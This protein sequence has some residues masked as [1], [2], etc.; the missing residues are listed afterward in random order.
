VYMS[1]DSSKTS[2]VIKAPIAPGMLRDV[3]IEN[4]QKMV[5]DVSYPIRIEKGIVALDGEREFSFKTGQKV[6]IRLRKNVFSTVN[7]SS[8]M[9]EIADKGLLCHTLV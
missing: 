6:S 1:D 2:I 4:H 5:A 3:H 9:H 8:C 7:V